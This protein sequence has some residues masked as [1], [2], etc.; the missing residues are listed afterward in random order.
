MELRSLLTF[1]R[2]GWNSLIE[3]AGFAFTV[4]QIHNIYSPKGT[5]SQNAANILMS[6]SSGVA[7][8]PLFLS[9]LAWTPGSPGQSV[10]WCP[11]QQMALSCWP[12]MLC[13][14]TEELVSPF[15]VRQSNPACSASRGGLSTSCLCRD[16]LL[17]SVEGF[18]FYSL[19]GEY[20]IHLPTDDWKGADLWPVR[21]SP[22]QLFKLGNTNSHLNKGRL[23]RHVIKEM[24]ISAIVYSVINMLK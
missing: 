6:Y 16:H 18:T 14:H 10:C 3:L 20:W 23:W 15:C 17:G 24:Q 5:L 9:L 19:T 4:M 2:G 1:D 22:P 12:Y 21:G 7:K 11:S 8:H 13:V